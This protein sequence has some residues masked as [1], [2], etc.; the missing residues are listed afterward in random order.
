MSRYRFVRF[1]KI[2]LEL[3]QGSK[4]HIERT[5]FDHALFIAGFN[6]VAR[7]YEINLLTLQIGSIHIYAFDP[8]QTKL[9]KRI[10]DK[11]GTTIP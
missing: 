10:E 3:L 9:L 1:A 7:R 2:E 11:T 6:E 4:V 5:D 8:K